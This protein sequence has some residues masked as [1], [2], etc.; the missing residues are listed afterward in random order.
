MAMLAELSDVRSKTPEV[1]IQPVASPVADVPSEHALGVSNS[2]SGRP[3]RFRAHDAAAAR[4]LS[5]SG[6][7]GALAQLLAARGV[8]RETAESFLAPK[9]KH[10]LPEPYLIANMH[11]AVARFAAAVKA[12]EKIAVFGDYDVDGACASALLLRFLRAL[13]QE[14]LLYIPDRMKEGY[15]PTAPAM[16][17]LRDQ[18]ASVVVTVDCG[19]T[20]VKALAAARELGLDVIVLDHHAVEQDPPAFAHVNPNGPSDASGLTY[21]CATGL[22]FIFVVAV[23]RVLR[24]DGWFSSVGLNP[25]DLMNELDLVALATIADVVPLKGVNRAFVKQGLIKLERLERPGFAALARVGASAPPYS[26]HHLGFVFGPRINAGGRVGRCDLG[27]RLLATHDAAEADA[28]ALDLDKHN[29]ERQ[30]IESHILEAA[31]AMAGGQANKAFMFVCGDHWHAGVIGII[32]G[33]LKE[34]HAKPVLVAGFDS[35]GD[36][37]LAR[38]SARSVAGIDLGAIIRAALAEGLL[39]TGGGH[40]MAAGFSLRRNQVA[41]FTEFLDARI[42]VQRPAV[43]AAREL[44]ADAI[45]SARGATLELLDT[46]ERAGPFGSG[47]PEPL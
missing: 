45:V 29:R 26:A 41:A 14:P 24:E 43:V 2:F 8:T 44:V 46:V 39:E 22:A 12:G 28:L 13:G 1:G 6:M 38:G 16:Q 20:A 33:R 25:L 10:L 23:Q 34:R 32:A 9:L 47:N 36:D 19:A 21:I 30:A 15:G 4:T 3:W 35:A 18:G 17:S 11:R 5:L 27:A 42:E 7:S 40:A 37:A 31:D